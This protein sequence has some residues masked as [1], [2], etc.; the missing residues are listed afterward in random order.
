MSYYSQF[1]N[2]YYCKYIIPIPIYIRSRKLKEEDI[3][4]MYQNITRKEQQRNTNNFRNYPKKIFRR[5]NNRSFVSRTSR[6][7][8]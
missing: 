3:T 1:P 5:Q 7:R 2:D 6:Q 8:K 4:S